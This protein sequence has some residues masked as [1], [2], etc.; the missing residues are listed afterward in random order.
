MSSADGIGGGWARFGREDLV[1][2]RPE[3]LGDA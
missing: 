2:E 3:P 1:A